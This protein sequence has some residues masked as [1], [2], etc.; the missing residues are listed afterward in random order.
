MI[1]PTSLSFQESALTDQ[2]LQKKYQQLR[3][4]LFSLGRVWIGFSGG[5]DSTLLLAIA[6]DVLGKENVFACLA[7]GP[8]LSE[9]EKNQAQALAQLLDAQIIEYAA[10]EFQ[11]PAY[12]ANGPDRCFHC[13][14][15]LFFHLDQFAKTFSENI[16]L[17]DT[18][19]TAKNSSGFLLYGGNA[20]DT[21]DFRPGRR[22]ALK[23]GA[24]APLAEAGLTK[25]EVRALSTAFGLPTADKAAQPCLSSR[26][27]YGNSVT[28]E[29]LAMVEAGEELLSKLG[30]TEYRLRHFGELAKIEVRLEEMHLF[31]K[32]F[33]DEK[34]ESEFFRGFNEIGFT[35]VEIDPAGFR[36]GS[37]NQVLTEAEKL[38]AGG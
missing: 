32:V 29:K 2:G 38:Q 13:K 8:S 12:V 21:H 37:L 35:Q 18:T 17:I 11:N 34:L 14:A 19:A 36:S 4:R 20:D 6:R 27:P 30:F 10:T 3:S 26:I 33:A 1:S 23:F 28:A 31:E 15:D 16:S 5:V 7:T 9:S 22:A 24:L 25:L